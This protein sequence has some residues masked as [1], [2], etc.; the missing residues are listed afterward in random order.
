MS[1]LLSLVETRASRRARVHTLLSMLCSRLRLGRRLRLRS[2]P[3]LASLATAWI[4]TGVVECP[5]QPHESQGVR[6]GG[7]GEGW[8]RGR[9]ETSS[10]P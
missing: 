3:R 1:C 10:L 4:R 5:T 8:E 9:K 2:R 7:G 6:W